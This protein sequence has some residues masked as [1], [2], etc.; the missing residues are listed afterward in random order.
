MSYNI[1][2]IEDNEDVRENIEEILDL[3]GYDVE[4]A[5][6]GKEG[7]KKAKEF[8]PDLIL[9][10]IMMPEMDGYDVIYF[11]GLDP[12]TSCIPFIFLTAKSE[13][14]DFRK[15]M[16][17]GADDYLT[18][19]F[20]DVTLVKAIEQ[21]LAKSNK[22]QELLKRVGGEVNDDLTEGVFKHTKTKKLEPKSFIYL[23]N[24]SPVYLYKVLKGQ[25]KLF[26][27]SEEGKELTTKI[28]SEGEYFGYHALLKGE[29]YPDSAVSLTEV[30]LE[31]IPS[32][33]FLDVIASN[34]QLSKH[35]IKLLSADV[36][37]LERE[38]LSLAYDSVKKRVANGL[39][40]YAD[41]QASD[42]LTIP[43]EELAHL[44]GTSTES[45]IRTLSEFKKD[46]LIEIDGKEITITKKK[47]LIH[48]KY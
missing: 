30:K 17:L 7:V 42:V 12:L 25:V 32:D 19:P 21:R 33:S 3:A 8:M 27:T 1:L 37:D 6:N 16:E 29:D 35:F 5:K 39:I 22:V 20:D 14:E 40:K 2:V 26:T 48:Y 34:S 13:K 23:E 28:V 41:K 15:G 46:G 38:L 11:L 45:V 4:V 47:D 43:R 31:L 10:D 44:A 24:S 18:K 36:V 9:C